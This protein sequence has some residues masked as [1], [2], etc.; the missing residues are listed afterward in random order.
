MLEIL[1]FLAHLVE[2]ADPL[3]A[4]SP[5]HVITV[6]SA[7]FTF[8]I[9]IMIL[10]HLLEKTSRPALL[11][12]TASLW[13]VNGLARTLRFCLFY[14]I[15]INFECLRLLTAGVTSFI[16]VSVAASEFFVVKPEVKVYNY[17]F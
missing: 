10:E 13:S 9:L 6:P 17:K 15:G 14:H 16:C 8:L 5:S 3:L 12:V 7:S 4:Y 11:F 2:I 1:L